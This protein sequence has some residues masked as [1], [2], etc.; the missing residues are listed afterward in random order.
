MTFGEDD[1]VLDFPVDHVFLN[2]RKEPALSGFESDGFSVF[3]RC[4][5]YL[6]GVRPE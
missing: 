3:E 4:P 6:L 5:Q 1:T 2:A